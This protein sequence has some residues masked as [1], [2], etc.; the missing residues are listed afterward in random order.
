MRTMTRVAMLPIIALA[1]SIVGCASATPAAIST[2]PPATNSETATKE[3]KPAIARVTV[4]ADSITVTDAEG[5]LVDA[6]DF[7]SAP[8]EIVRVL[9]HAFGVAPDTVLREVPCNC[10][11]RWNTEYNWEGFQLLD[12]GTT[13]TPSDQAGEPPYLTVAQVSVTA[14]SVHG[15]QI[16]TAQ[17]VMVGDDAAPLTA[18]QPSDTV[19][20][21]AAPNN[22][23]L[24][25]FDLGTVEL[26]D[27][28]Y[29]T[30]LSFS[31]HVFSTARDG[32]VTG[33]IAPINNNFGL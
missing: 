22:G 27:D 9:T 33:I 4:L 14:A 23:D 5:E 18:N 29:S 7:F 16:D 32:I 31:V 19:P 12:E 25:R 15:V 1:L 26:P 10:D 30:G 21:Y 2:P 13:G 11:R 6:V 8:A 3:P 28:S 20:N 17:G 24:T